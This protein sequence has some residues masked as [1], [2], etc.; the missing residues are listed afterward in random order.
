MF[1]DYLTFK[2]SWNNSLASV[3]FLPT[4]YV[5]DFVSNRAKIYVEIVPPPL[6]PPALGPLATPAA[7]SNVS[8]ILTYLASS[9]QDLVTF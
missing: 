2:K 9:R 1:R 5:T 6:V 7:L 3:L 4:Q 8:L